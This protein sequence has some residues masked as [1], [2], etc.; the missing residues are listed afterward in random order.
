MSSC[1][2]IDKEEK[3]NISLNG[4]ALKDGVLIIEPGLSNNMKIKPYW[5]LISTSEIKCIII[6]KLPDEST[7]NFHKKIGKGEDAEIDLGPMTAPPVYNFRAGNV[8]Q[9]GYGL[10]ILMK[11]KWG[12]RSLM[13]FYF[14]QG[15]SDFATTVSVSEFR[16]IKSGQIRLI[17]DQDRFI[18]FNPMF[19]VEST[20]GLRLLNL[21]A[22]YPVSASTAMYGY[23]NHS[24]W[25]LSG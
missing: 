9:K 2:Q 25:S 13:Q 11:R 1:K 4:K 16:H 23:D 20:L 24:K 8:Y 6:K 22:V 10:E 7:E 5:D 18:L 15:L 12:I 14:N 17:E 19:G 3:V 21:E